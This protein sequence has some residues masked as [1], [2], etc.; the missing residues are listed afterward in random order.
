MK[1]CLVALLCVAIFALSSCEK[2][3]YDGDKVFRVVPNDEGQL[4]KLM[5]MT[6]YDVH[7]GKLSF[8]RSPSLVGQSSDVHVKA[9]HVDAFSAFLGRNHIKFNVH[10]G[11]V[12]RHMDVIDRFNNELK[13]FA[14]NSIVGTFAS[15]RDINNWL[16]QQCEKY[17]MITKCG[18][19]GL[20]YENRDMRYIRIG[21][22]ASSPK[23]AVYITAGIHAREW[24]SP[25]T[26]IWIMDHML[27]NYGSDQDITK[28]VDMF[29]WYVLPVTNPDG[30]EFTMSPDGDRLWRKTRSPNSIA[31]C[32]GT[33]G[34]RNYGFHW[35]AKKNPCAED[36]P[37]HE[38]MSEKELQNL[39]KFMA[40]Q[41]KT[42]PGLAF[43][44]VHTY[45]DLWM[46]VYAYAKKTYPADYD[47]ELRVAKIG[48]D[49]LMAVN[50]QKWTVGNVA[51]ILYPAAGS[52][53]D[54]MKGMGYAKYSYGMEL[55]G[56]NFIVPASD[57]VP[58]G[59]EVFAGFKAA[60]MA[61]K[62]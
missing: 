43:V 45:G 12:Q 58:S 52:S 16:S 1:A 51:D 40:S 31:K 28:M 27:T 15:H 38:A 47:E 20:S 37:G 60:V 55:R 19:M 24:L 49:A 17:S 11:D 36:Y 22:P 25:A 13:T 26:M 14:N 62:P 44:D 42:Q 35:E 41:N 48:A 6:D 23:H 56:D 50:N 18:S 46:L 34:N 3:K 8:W 39:G 32:P 61:M 53:A 54:F 10:V 9:D 4:A 7:E 33:D 29:D 57:I 30:Y 5:A 59:K 2:T 21:K